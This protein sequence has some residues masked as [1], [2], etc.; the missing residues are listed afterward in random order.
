LSFEEQEG[1]P[2]DL[3]TV[4]EGIFRLSPEL[5]RKAAAEHF[6]KESSFDCPKRQDS[7][8]AI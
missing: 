6:K 7:R 3:F 4:I 5:F 1:T 8:N 2:H